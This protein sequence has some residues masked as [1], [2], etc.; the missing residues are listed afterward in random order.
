MLQLRLA[1]LGMGNLPEPLSKQTHSLR[2]SVADFHFI[3][4]FPIL[5]ILSYFQSRY[6]KNLK[7]LQAKDMSVV[8]RNCFYYYFFYLMFCEEQSRGAGH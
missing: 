4:A 6:K 1:H 5:A 8:Y 7:M 2:I 3:N